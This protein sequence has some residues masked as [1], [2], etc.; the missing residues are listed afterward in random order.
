M[1]AAGASKMIE[2]S[3]AAAYILERGDVCKWFDAD[4]LHKHVTLFVHYITKW[5]I[6]LQDGATIID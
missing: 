6:T 1:P 2:N 3:R 4:D 5:Y